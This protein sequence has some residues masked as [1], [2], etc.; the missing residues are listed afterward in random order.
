MR[1]ELLKEIFSLAQARE[2]VAERVEDYQSERLHPRLACE[3][4]AAYP[5]KFIGTG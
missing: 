1:D 5:A 3:T 2:A 4:P